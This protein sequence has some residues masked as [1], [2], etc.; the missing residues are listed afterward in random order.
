MA[1]E[2]IDVAALLASGEPAGVKAALEDAIL[3]ALEHDPAG[4]PSS[5]DLLGS[6]GDEAALMLPFVGVVKSLAAS[7]YVEFDTTVTSSWRLTEFGEEVLREGSP[8]ARLYAVLPAG[9]EG[10]ERDALVAAV[11]E[12]TVKV[13]QNLCVRNKWARVDKAT[14]RLVRTA[15]PDTIVDADRD[16]ARRVAAG[17][18]LDEKT[19][20]AL[21]KRRM[22]QKVQ[23]TDYAVRRA[24]RY[25]RR[26][27]KQVTD[28]TREM[29]DAGA[30]SWESADLKDYNW[31]ARGRKVEA[32]CIHPLLKVRRVF[33]DTLLEMG[34]TEM[35]TN[36]YVESSF[37]N[38]DALFQPQAH[39]AR[40]AHDT[41][42]LSTAA[43]TR[44]LPAKY[45]RTVKETHES[46]GATGSMGHRT[47]WLESEARKNVL[48][49]HTTAVSA[50]MLHAIGQGEF[51]PAR[52]FSID[53]VF[54]NETLDATHLA[55]FHQVEGVVAGYNLTLGDLMGTI[56]EFFKR[57]GIEGLIAKPAF[58][59][60]T[61]PSM[62]LFARGPSGKMMEIGNSG[63]FR[64]EMIE[65]MGLPKG[66]TVIAWGLS[67][68]RPTM[69]KY[70][71]DDIRK[72][73]GHTMNL[74][75][76]QNNPI[77]RFDV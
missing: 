57:I 31:R 23:H 41:F 50:R 56:E 53:R 44:T 4:L 62:E 19:M 68:E 37:W 63:I 66:V 6:L 27:A 15:E 16:L 47:P 38:F 1:E 45:M 30:S 17:E 21:K 5:A 20:K 52:L 42:F 18:V 77:P 7:L 59:P 36:N 40:D 14:R 72:L 76:I 64:P 74:P 48:R 51:R 28:V 49:T 2:K 12:D 26:R 24:E 29:L 69:I 25:R 34:F 71:I 13:G 39:P 60:Y 58:N 10:A 65:P 32:G 8:E 46:G 22:V 61:E 73:C 70:G 55:E 35:P 43:E 75:M 54:R 3:A 33:R 11:G 67:L 9:D